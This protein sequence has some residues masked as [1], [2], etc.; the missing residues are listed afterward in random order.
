MPDQ[1]IFSKGFANGW[2]SAARKFCKGSSPEIAADVTARALRRDWKEIGGIPNLSELHNMLIKADNNRN[3]KAVYK[4][5]QE[6]KCYERNS[7]N[8]DFADS[9]KKA[10][11]QIHLESSERNNTHGTLFPTKH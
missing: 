3:P 9:E 1:D 10:V 5:F 8:R 11:I 7:V 6:L 2:K 4:L